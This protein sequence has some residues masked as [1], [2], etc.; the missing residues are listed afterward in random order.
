M[1]PQQIPFAL[2]LFRLATGPVIV[3]FCIFKPSF[4][5]QICTV[6][7]AL[8]V[9]S[10]IF[11]G[12]IARRLN[13]VTP[14][15]RLWDSRCDVIFWLCV[16]IGIHLLYPSIWH[17]TWIMLAILGSMELMTHLIS[18]IRFRREA[19]THHLLSKLFCLCLWALLS[20]I[21]LI[22]QTGWLFWFTLGMGIASQ[23]EAIL[24]TLV[25]PHWQVDT[26]NLNVAL[27]LRS[28]AQSHP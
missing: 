21:F 10:D 13:C 19:S 1:R 4:T 22:G 12:I 24:I 25:L 28:E 9:I 27:K 26:K 16:A 18:F 5:P 2:V 14:A 7:L 8:G 3:A 11:D 20:Q 17:T 15:L 6:L 23:A